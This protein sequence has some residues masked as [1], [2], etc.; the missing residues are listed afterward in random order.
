M[1]AA[2]DPVDRL[3]ERRQKLSIKHNW[4]FYRAGGFDQV[5]LETGADLLNLDSLDQKLWVA[6]ACP[7]R[8]IEFDPKTLDLIDTDKDGRIRAPELIAAIQW[9]GGM[10]RNAD[11]LLKSS[12]S[13]ALSSINDTTPTGRQILASARRVLSNLGKKDATAIAVEDFADPTQIFAQTAATGNGDGI[14]P[15]E[16]ASDA[17]TKAVIA[18]IIACLGAETDRSG[19][20]GVSQGKVDTFFADAT[21]FSDWN[22]KAATDAA[23]VLPLGDATPGAVA[24]VK[25]VKAKVDDYF[26]RC[27]LAAFD[28]RAI[29]ALNREEKDY[30]ALAAKDLSITAAEVAG[31]PLAKIEA[32]RPL[33]LQDGVNPAWA[34]ALAALQATVVKPLLGDKTSL[35]ES[36]WTTLTGKVAAYETWVGSKS[37]TSVE[38][39]G[40][41]RVRQILAG[42]SKDMI[43]ALIAK[44][45]AL[46]PEATAIG[47]V[48]KLVRLNRDLY[49]LAN[50]F[51]AFRDFYSRSAKAIFQAGTLYLD[52]R[53][54]E[55]CVHVTDGGKHAAMAG[56]AKAYLAYV[57]CTRPSGEK[58]TIA[59][60]FTDGDS[61]N[62]MVGRNGIFYDRKGRDWDATITKIVD[63]PISIRQAFW[64]PYKKFVRML[65]E[66][67][68]K[69]AA[70]AEAAA[71]AKVAGA[72]TAVAN[73]DKT[74]A[75]P[76]EP[77]KFDVGVV[78]A[79]GVGVGAIGA[80][81]GGLISGFIG[82]GMWMPIGLLGIILAISGPSMLVA[83]LKLRQRNLGPILDANGWAVNAKAK[84]NVPFGG[85]L[86]DVAKLPPGAEYNPVDPYAEP[87]SP[88]PK[89]IVFL[90]ILALAYVGLDKFGKIHEWTDGKLGKPAKAAVETPAAAPAPAPAPAK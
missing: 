23:K 5:R 6:L 58:M 1:L 18:D 26:S 44:D 60:A 9:V 47:S 67:A 30:L 61:D 63:N 51:V 54:C 90:I 84:L 39:L 53:S 55:L 50:N 88:W 57:D 86:T 34:G 12:P 72:A 69:R 36:D 79:L 20:P 48:E 22:Q 59:A 89:V 74:K 35:T 19:K 52:G 65:E 85:A 62:L 76:P 25:A 21:A 15:A 27:R 33:P 24:A 42:K 41:Q 14:V 7:T 71:D 80:L 64:A 28:A 10:L 37:G 73:A 66:M 11:D 29:A 17:D 46:E 2:V 78:A 32:G 75:A 45:K 8:G 83:W 87:S 13:L 77:K 31:F 82:L 40:L 68:A 56:L 16:A 49:Q 38:K 81:L 4:K 3:N 70:A 43:G